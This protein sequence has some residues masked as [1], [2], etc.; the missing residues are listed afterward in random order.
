[1]HSHF[2]SWDIQQVPKVENDIWQA[3]PYPNWGILVGKI[4]KERHLLFFG[5]Y[6]CLKNLDANYE[7][8]FNHSKHNL[9]IHI[10]SKSKV[11][12]MLE[13]LTN[14]MKMQLTCLNQMQFPI[15]LISVLKL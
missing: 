3:K 7:R 9:K 11:H 12:M 1:M 14:A 5:N 13:S 4:S 10:V 8:S 15:V 6:E 2:G